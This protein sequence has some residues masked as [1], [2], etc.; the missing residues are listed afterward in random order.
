MLEKRSLSSALEKIGLSEK[1]ALVYIALVTLQSA[2]AYTIAQH[3]DVKKPTV[4]VILEDLR[5]KGLVL[6][7][8][9][10]KKML[11]APRSLDEYLEEQREH[12]RAAERIIPSLAELSQGERAHVYFFNGLSGMRDALA[13]KFDDMRGKTFCS[14]YGNLKGA[15]EE[16]KNLYASWDKKAYAADVHFRLIMSQAEKDLY[17][18][19]TMSLAQK[20]PDQ[21]S[22]HLVPHVVFPPNISVEIGAD[23]IRI[24]DAIQLTATI[25]DDLSTSTTFRQIFE[26]VWDTEQVFSPQKT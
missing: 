7:V 2:T 24:T 16:L 19:E 23:F 18:K 22:I 21:L 3:C 15:S 11:F 1:E 8:P 20:Y 17:Y 9:H 25:I 14:F 10:A 6:V 26:I 12:I 4:Y 5:K 13:H